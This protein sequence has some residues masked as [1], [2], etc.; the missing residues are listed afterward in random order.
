MTLAEV[1]LK[2]A[3]QLLEERV[4]ARAGTRIAMS[5]SGW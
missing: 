4:V 1:M 5:Q 2:V 3:G